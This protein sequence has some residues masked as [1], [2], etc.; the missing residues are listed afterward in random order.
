M[1]V[2]AA[3]QHLNDSPPSTSASEP[4]PEPVPFKAKLEAILQRG[5]S[6]RLQQRPGAG[7]GAGT[8]TG[9]R[10]RPQSTYIEEIAIE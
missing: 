1:K 5:P 10:R 8:D 2:V 6:H 7:A 9:I 4:E 3:A